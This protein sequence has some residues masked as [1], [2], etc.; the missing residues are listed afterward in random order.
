MRSG[1][2]RNYTSG[3]VA[4]IA[5]WAY[6]HYHLDGHCVAVQTYSASR[7]FDASDLSD[8]CFN[9]ETAFPVRLRNSFW[10]G[11]GSIL[12]AA[13]AA[14][15]NPFSVMGNADGLFA[16]NL[17]RGNRPFFTVSAARAGLRFQ[18]S[19]PI[20][21][22]RVFYPGDNEAD[23]LKSLTNYNSDGIWNLCEEDWDAVLLPLRRAWCSTAG[24]R[25]SN[26]NLV[27]Q[28]SGA[29]ILS[30]V[31]RQMLNSNFSNDNSVNNF[32]HH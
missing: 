21:H 28:Y 18:R 24:G 11:N 17:W 20:G 12:V 2:V 7:N 6:R 1:I 5:A 10:G 31:A 16:N 8:D 3:L 13:Q 29:D 4:S 25:W 26:F 27:K 22:Y 19:D 30:T 23:N 9:G 14:A 15:F 32:I